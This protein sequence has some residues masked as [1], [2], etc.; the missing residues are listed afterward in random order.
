MFDS[1]LGLAVPGEIENIGPCR[2]GLLKFVPNPD[3]DGLTFR[4][5]GVILVTRSGKEID[6]IYSEQENESLADKSFLDGGLGRAFLYKHPLSSMEAEDADGYDWS[7]YCVINRGSSAVFIGYMS[8]D[9]SDGF[10]FTPDSN[11]Q[12]VIMQPPYCY[13]EIIGAGDTL[14]LRMP[15]ISGTIFSISSDG[16]TLYTG[17]F[18]AASMTALTGVASGTKPAITRHD[19]SGEFERK[20]EDPDSDDYRNADISVES[21]AAQNMPWNTR[22]VTTGNP[23]ANAGGSITDGSNTHYWWNLNE[24]PV[25]FRPQQVTP[26]TPHSFSY[27]EWYESTIDAHIDNDEVAH[28]LVLRFIEWDATFNR[29]GLTFIAVDDGYETA[30][31]ETPN[32]VEVLGWHTHIKRYTDT[33]TSNEGFA[34]SGWGGSSQAMILERYNED[35]SDYYYVSHDSYIST[36]TDNSTLYVDIK[37]GNDVV[38]TLSVY[39]YQRYYGRLLLISVSAMVN[40]TQISTAIDWIESDPDDLKTEWLAKQVIFVRYTYGSNGMYSLGALVQKG[41]VTRVSGN[42]V[43]TS[44]TD[45]KLYLGD[46]FARGKYYPGTARTL[47]G[48]QLDKP[49]WCAYDPLTDSISDVYDHPILFQ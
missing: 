19:I 18:T 31:T 10:L 46:I 16:R 23:V 1:I 48:S 5:G 38:D 34:I 14:M 6:H 12:A 40:G 11:G 2:H 25:V 47:T 30:S 9:I 44:F 26:P 15:S 41:T 35:V 45:R 42:L 21:G 13:R 8:N 4:D 7:G 17:T 43:F 22:N 24:G 3:P 37:I 20:S 29:N 39:E 28:P 32:V 27:D 49:L 33:H 36:R